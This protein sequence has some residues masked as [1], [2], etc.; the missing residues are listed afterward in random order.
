LE[1]AAHARQPASAEWLAEQ[2]AALDVVVAW[3]LGWK[4]R[5]ARLLAEHPERANRR[6]GE[7]ATTPLHEAVQRDD[8]EL[9]QAL[10]AARPD[11]SIKDATFGATPLG[12]AKHMRRA[13]MVE[14]IERYQGERADA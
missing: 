14:L 3:D 5:V 7:M 9:A 4:E 11:V 13:R 1:L 10:L 2:G 12:W 6:R 8:H